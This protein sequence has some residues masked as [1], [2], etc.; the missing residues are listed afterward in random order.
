MDGKLQGVQGGESEVQLLRTPGG[1]NFPTPDDTYSAPFF[2]SGG[3]KFDPYPL[4]LHKH[5]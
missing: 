1:H 4:L 5:H 2:S 3:S